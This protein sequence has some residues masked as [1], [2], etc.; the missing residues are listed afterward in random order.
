MHKTV[1][2]L[3]RLCKVFCSVNECDS[4]HINRNLTLIQGVLGVLET[5]IGSLELK[6]GSLESEKIITGF[7]KSKKIGSL[8]S[9]KSCPYRTIPGT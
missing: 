3:P 4:F 5:R 6:I 2:V 7:Q 8:E 9:A 1:A